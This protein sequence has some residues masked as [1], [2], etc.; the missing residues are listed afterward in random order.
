MSRNSAWWLSAALSAVTAAAGQAEVLPE[1]WRHWVAMAGILATGLSALNAH[2]P[3]RADVPRPPSHGAVA[4]PLRP[5]EP[6]D[7]LLYGATGFFGRV[8][9]LKTWHPIAHVECYIGNGL[10]VASRD[11]IGTGIYP[12]RTA[13]LVMICRPKVPLDVDRALALFTAVPHR[14]YGWID[15]LQFVG[16]NINTPGIVCSP[17]IT[18]FLRDGGLDPF[19]GEPAERIAPFQFM[20]SPV[21]QNLQAVEVVANA[22]SLQR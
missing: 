4:G 18:E 12:V 2:W 7:V 19:N 3:R 16:L 13:G 9:A 17:C 8:I 6:G 1:P 11:G 22:E 5:L 15:L 21:F 10:S 14:P 20:T